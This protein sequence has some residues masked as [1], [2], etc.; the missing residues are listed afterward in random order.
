MKIDVSVKGRSVNLSCLEFGFSAERAIIKPA[1]FKG[2]ASA[3]RA[4]IR[5][6]DPSKG[7]YTLGRDMY[8]YLDGE[9][10]EMT[11]LLGRCDEAFVLELIHNSESEAVS[12]E[13]LDAPWELLADGNGFL[14]ASLRTP[15]L[16]IRRVAPYVSSLPATEG[17]LPLVFMAAQAGSNAPLRFEQEEAAILRAV[18]ETGL[19]LI[20]EESGS[21]RF[22]RDRV[23]QTQGPYLLHLSAHGRFDYARGP[24]MVMEME[25]GGPHHVSASEMAERLS[26]R[27]PHFL[28]LSACHSAASAA[29]TD[30]LALALAKYGFPSVLG[31][32]GTVEDDEA[33][34]FTAELYER[35]AEGKS[36]ESAVMAARHILLHDDRKKAFPSHNWHLPRLYLGPHGGGALTS[37]KR[38]GAPK[39]PLPAREL[40]LGSSAGT[41]LAPLP[42]FAGYRRELQEVLRVF[43]EGPSLGVVIY[44]I[45]GQGKTSLAA[46]VAGRL[47]KHRLISVASPFTSRELLTAIQEHL[48]QHS[49][50]R[51]SDETLESLSAPEVDTGSLARVLLS[52]LEGPLNE[53][54]A[55]I[56]IDGF[57]LM[58]EPQPVGPHRVRPYARRAVTA[59]VRAFADAATLSRLLFTSRAMFEL[60]DV[61]ESPTRRLA[62]IQLCSAPPY[63]GLKRAAMK[64]HVRGLQHLPSEVANECV[65]VGFG[66]PGLE[67]LLL[68][69]AYGD[70]P[71]LREAIDSLRAYAAGS[72]EG[73]SNDTVR[74][75]LNNLDIEA[76]MRT[77]SPSEREL[78]RVASI[79]DAPIPASTLARLQNYAHAITESWIPL[80]TGFLQI[81]ER[82][83]GRKS[84]IDV[85]RRLI[86]LGLMEAHRDVVNEDLNAIKVHPLVI[87][88]TRRMEYE[89]FT[90]LA[91]YIA[92]DLFA[93]WSQGGGRRPHIASIT[94]LSIGLTARRP[95]IVSATATETLVNLWNDGEYTQGLALGKRAIKMLDER[96]VPT[97]MSLLT[98]AGKYAQLLGDSALAASYFERAVKL[99]REEGFTE[100]NKYFASELLVSY[101]MVG[102]GGY[103]FR[104]IISLFEG[105]EGGFLG[106]SGL[107]NASGN[108][109]AGFGDGK[110]GVNLGEQLLS[111]LSKVFQTTGR[112]ES[113]ADTVKDW[114]IL[115]KQSNPQTALR[116]NRWALE[117]YEEIG[118]MESQLAV[119]ES[120]QN[121]LIKMAAETEARASK[122][123]LAEAAESLRKFTRVAYALNEE[124]SRS[125]GLYKLVRVYI[126]LGEVEKACAEIPETCELFS[127]IETPL[128]PGQTNAEVA[129]L[130]DAMLAEEQL[131]K[132]DSR[133]A[134]ERLERAVL[135][136]E[137]KGHREEA[138]E[139][140][141]RL[142]KYPRQ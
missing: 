68:H 72:V 35:L 95:Q 1:M 126:E 64:A 44:G 18:A 16:P 130:L 123:L 29:A 83:E 67:S 78:L 105:A 26:D 128:I 24:I 85:S 80:D 92:D 118:D 32:S 135:W 114:A 141:S 7:L 125:I 99:L 115:C 112:Q 97:P 94:L 79:F 19:D 87:P 102:G 13:L 20:V 54:P 25:V 51:L 15:C 88:I 39:S 89:E 133:S 6:A 62:T 100:D 108:S 12:K 77:L 121:L 71:E 14:A 91:S 103:N 30:S 47:T 110:E 49:P 40:Y 69:L 81:L 52:W 56:A 38:S 75:Y 139:L 11:S 66:N 76:L 46:R 5:K 50:Y 96:G 119:L 41:P 22:L 117:L 127:K 140:R 27:I 137:E 3:Y 120:L 74:T 116:L 2:W 59:L 63:E 93:Q 36:I 86:A 124:T 138:R 21:L 107:G 42:E 142:G 73:M 31:W 104:K 4:L 90:F 101:A 132:G 61:G 34:K 122:S 60:E 129:L 82:F 9:G 65:E 113:L 45:G 57:E 58:L 136:L 28:F 53:E 17:T 134:R 84:N 48:P 33:T 109:G 111:A 98:V 43:S 23:L 55:L 131:R 37:A 10:G 70:A 106:A 8:R